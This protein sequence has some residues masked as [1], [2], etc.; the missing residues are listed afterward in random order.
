M[1]SSLARGR[2]S[3]TIGTVSQ[4]RDGHFFVQTDDLS[5]RVR[6]DLQH[7]QQSPDVGEPVYFQRT[8]PTSA[9]SWSRSG[10]RRVR[11]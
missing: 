2:G 7:G 8:D 5:A 10:E 11:W 9:S 1:A 4:V 6:V 3:S